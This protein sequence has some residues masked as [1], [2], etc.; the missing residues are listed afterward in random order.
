MPVA[1]AVAVAGCGASHRQRLA[2][3]PSVTPTCAHL[4][5]SEALVSPAVGYIAG[6]GGSPSCPA[7]ILESHDGGRTFIRRASPHDTVNIVFTSTRDGWDF[8]GSLYR[9]RDGAKS[10]QLQPMPGRANAL[11]AR[12][13]TVIALL[14]RCQRRRCRQSLQISHNNGATWTR[15]ALNG[16]TAAG[17]DVNEQVLLTD[18]AHGYVLVGPRT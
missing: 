11:A 9:T 16:S 18:P 13:A 10:W 6:S 4:L 3:R 2:A 5:F 1:V 8:G 12:A 14:D 7:F 17:A 15:H